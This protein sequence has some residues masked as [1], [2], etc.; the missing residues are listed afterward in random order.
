MSQE[1][2]PCAPYSGLNA[3]VVAT[4]ARAT[5]ETQGRG[6]MGLLM[7]DTML[8][9]PTLDDTLR[10]HDGLRAWAYA[11]DVACDGYEHEAAAPSARS[12]MTFWSAAL[13]TDAGQQPE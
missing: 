1:R 12:T 9:G 3:A 8:P 4:A 2:A 5:P 7:A 6:T 13:A 11:S 10:L